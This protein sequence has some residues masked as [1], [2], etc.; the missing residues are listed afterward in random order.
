MEY[1]D[2]KR[3]HM[4]EILMQ[5]Y[6]RKENIYIKHQGNIDKLLRTYFKNIRQKY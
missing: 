1:L 4:Y 2:K 3:Q 5:M 6:D